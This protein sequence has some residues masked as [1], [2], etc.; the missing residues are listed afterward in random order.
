MRTKKYTQVDSI[1]SKS[2]KMYF[3][4][5]SDIQKVNQKV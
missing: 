2:I 4:N 1:I 5:I 3:N